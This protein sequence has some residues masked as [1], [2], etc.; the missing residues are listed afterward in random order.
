[1]T[2]LP[3]PYSEELKKLIG[4]GPREVYRVLY[5]NRGNPLTMQEIRDLIGERGSDEQ[6]DRRKR[7]LHPHF[8]IRRTG[9]GKNTRYELVGRVDRDSGP[10]LGLSERERAAVLQVGRCAMCGR[11]PL[12]DRVKLQVDHKIPRNW[13]GTNDPA[14]LQPLCEEC[15]RG[16]KDLFAAMDDR[17]AG[18][19]NE[20]EPHKRIGELLKAFEGEWLPSYVI[21]I[22][23]SA[24]Q[25]QEDWQKR[26]RELRVLGWDYEHS[27]QRDPITGRVTTSYRLV[28]WEPWPT[29]SVRSEIRRREHRNI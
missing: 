20:E 24:K 5:E 25:Y 10:Q 15:N 11:S 14:N 17:I 29:G 27:R 8:T 1:M 23:A 9:S 18:P 13:G 28:R 16:K 4:I 21:G 3:E 6:L 12:E 19:I 26:M 7:E 2:D 22:V